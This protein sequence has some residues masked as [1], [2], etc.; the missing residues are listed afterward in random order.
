MLV[1][2]TYE[3]TI[4]KKIDRKMIPGGKEI[5]EKQLL[6]Q[7]DKIEKIEVDK[8]QIDQF[9]DVIYKKLEWLSREEL[10]DRFVS[11]EFTRFLSYYKLRLG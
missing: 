8:G 6:D 2:R 5:C 9:K 1:V 10:I 4:G 11:I 3:K 7:I